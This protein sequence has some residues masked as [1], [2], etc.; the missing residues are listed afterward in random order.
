MQEC[1]QARAGAPS[2]PFTKPFVVGTEMAYVQQVIAS[3]RIDADGEYTKRC[4]RFLEERFGITRVFMMPS[5]TAALELAASLCDLRPGD[6]VILPSY[7]FTSTATSVARLGARPVFVEIRPDTLTLDEARIEAAITK[8]TR[9]ILPV[10]YA[11]VSCEMDTI[12]AIARDHNLKVI[13]DAAQGVNAAYKGRALGSIGQLGAYSFHSTKNIVCGEGGALCCNDPAMI[14][15]AEILRDKGTNRAQFF[16]G[17]VDKYTWVDMG[18]SYLPSELACAFLLGQFEAMDS[19]LEQRR[20]IAEYY[21]E[22]LEPMAAAGRFR[23]PVVPADCTTHHRAFHLI[24]NDGA[25]R[26]NLMAYLRAD[27]IQAVFHYIPLHTSPMGRGFGYREGDLPRTEDLA[28][29][30]LRLPAFVG[31]T[32]VEQERV[33]DRIERFFAARVPYHRFRG[34]IELNSLGNSQALLGSRR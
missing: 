5:C 30:V 3:G 25:T 34:A 12:L 24:L 29:R 21:R 26:D 11:G 23:L 15:Q 31:L 20:R 18:S 28:G 13:E 17:E 14:A 19:I 7:T 10:H 22:R 2:I 4:A 6:E 9:A 8:R 1:T 32:E 33:V 27:G 16:R